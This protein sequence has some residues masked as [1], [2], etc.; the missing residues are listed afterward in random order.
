MR[1]LAMLCFISGAIT[2][3]IPVNVAK[4]MSDEELGKIHQE[5]REKAARMGG[6]KHL[7]IKACMEAA[8]KKHCAANRCS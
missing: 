2:F 7:M 5:C 8:T 4:S 1:N 6:T 3:F